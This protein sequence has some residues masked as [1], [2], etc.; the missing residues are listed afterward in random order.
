MPTLQ[1]LMEKDLGFSESVK[2]ASVN[3]GSDDLDRIAAELGLDF[4]KTAEEEEDSKED[5]KEDKEEKEE[6]KEASVSLGGLYNELF[7]EDGMLSKTA[8]EQ[9]KVAYEQNLGA[10]AYD[11]FA[12]R[13]D[14]RVEK[15]AADV[16]SGSATV[17][18]STAAEHD[19]NPHG[20][21]TPPQAQKSNKPANASD[22]I[23]TSPVVTDEVKALNDKRTVGDYE[24][25][26]AAIKNAALH[27][28]FLLS[29]LE[30]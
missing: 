22:K 2:T 26:H 16:L 23:D 13:W 10:L 30:D 8:E 21:T 24:Q 9:E 6:K 25:K 29:Q 15:L 19:G 17:S 20:D 3:N 11:A 4:G 7:P 18:S 5:K 27:K 1:E 12:S 14:R 28:A